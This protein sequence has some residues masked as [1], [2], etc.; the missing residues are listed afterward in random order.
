[1][2]ALAQYFSLAGSI[3]SVVL[4]VYF[5]FVK[6]RKERPNL[7]LY[8]ADREFFLGT[9]TA[10]QRQLG[11]KMGIIVANYS[12]LPNALLDVQLSLKKRDGTLLEVED[13]KFDQQTPMP[14]NVPALQTVL[15]RVIGRVRFPASATLEQDKNIGAAYANHFLAEP[16]A[17]QV[18]VKALNDKSFQDTLS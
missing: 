13:V 8:L 7:R 18:E 12:S 11:L 17:V 1:M 4:T 10:E 5:W 9:G 15:L 6:S 3:F 14:F 16:R 2:D